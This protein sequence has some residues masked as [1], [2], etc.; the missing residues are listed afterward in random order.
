M[1]NSFGKNMIDGIEA[2]LA[3]ERLR[4]V[5]GAR[6]SMLVA[7]SGGVDSTLVLKVAHDVLGAR[8]AGLLAVSPSLPVAERQEAECLAAWI[9]I[10]LHVVTSRE[11]ESPAY[12]ANGED[13]CYFCKSE[14]FGILEN[15]AKKL[16]FAS[17]AFGANIDD[18][19]DFRPGMTAAEERRIVAPLIEAGLGKAMVRAVARGLRLPNWD[20][21]ARACLASRIP[22]GM[23]VTPE[24]LAAV[25]RAEEGLIGL[26]FRQIRVRH[27]GDVARIEVAEE[28]MARLEDPALRQAVSRAV[29]AAGFRYV[30]LDLDGYRQGSLNPL[31]LL[32]DDGTLLSE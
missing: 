2:A 6:E 24:R 10:P 18:T 31:K 14:L 30:A 13:R 28:E 26:G 7:Y 8:A 16:G 9:G 25:E 19:G 17:L 5:V 21:P 1:D 23:E 11:M 22:H 12:R 29:R 15:E 20:K 27:H 3:H 32:G 4:S